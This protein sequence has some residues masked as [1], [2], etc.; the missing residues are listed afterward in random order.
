MFLEILIGAFFQYFSLFLF[1]GSRY[2]NWRLLFI[3]KRSDT[4]CAN[5]HYISLPWQK[6]QLCGKN[7]HWNGIPECSWYNGYGSRYYVLSDIFIWLEVLFFLGNWSISPNVSIS[8]CTNR[9][10]WTRCILGEVLEFLFNT[11]VYRCIVC[12]TSWLCIVLRETT[13]G[14][15]YLLLEEYNC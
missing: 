9:R 10:W 13:S 7:G 15:I 2:S 11:R 5:L 4:S 6:L 3:S 14:W 1:I 12:N 8:N